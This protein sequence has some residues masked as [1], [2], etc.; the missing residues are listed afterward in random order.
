MAPVIFWARYWADPRSGQNNRSACL[1]ATLP[2][3][4]FLLL[5]YL[6]A[7]ERNH[8]QKAERTGGSRLPFFCCV[9]NQP[10]ALQRFYF[11]LTRPERKVL[12]VTG[13]ISRLS[14]T[15]LPATVVWRHLLSGRWIQY[16]CCI[17]F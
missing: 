6:S 1:F 5:Q 10:T 9:Y 17:P 14:T 11:W 3:T 4:R 15:S 8:F 13:H 16:P 7:A 12:P 2:A